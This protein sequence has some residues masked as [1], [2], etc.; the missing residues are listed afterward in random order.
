MREPEC[1]GIGQPV[2]SLDDQRIERPEE[3]EDP[4]Q[5]QDE[6]PGH[7]ITIGRSEHPSH[8][9]DEKRG[10]GEQHE[11]AAFMGHLDHKVVY[12]DL[13]AGAAPSGAEEQ[14][15]GAPPDCCQRRFDRRDSDLVL[16]KRGR[17]E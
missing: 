5:H 9:E 11:H 8:W 7:P 3:H 2:R 1:H 17:V 12:H 15:Q 14:R 13:T 4:R 16:E 6:L 10:H